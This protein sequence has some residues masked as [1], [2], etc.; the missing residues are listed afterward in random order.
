M[1]IGQNLF[2]MNDTQKIIFESHFEAADICYA[3]QAGTFLSVDT[4]VLSGKGY[5]ITDKLNKDK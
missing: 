1:A 2:F 5:Q 3:K 4:I